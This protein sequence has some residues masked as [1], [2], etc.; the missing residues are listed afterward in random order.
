MVSTD[1]VPVTVCIPAWNEAATIAMTIE[2]VFH[3]DYP[4]IEEIIVCT[5]ACTDRTEEIVQSMDRPGLRLLSIPERGKALAWNRLVAECRTEI[6][7]FIDADI[8]IPPDC[9]GGLVNSLCK[10]TAIINSATP[11][12]LP[13]SIRRAARVLK[14]PVTI[15]R[16]GTI[17]ACCY[18]VKLQSLF[19]HLQ[20]RGLVGM[21]S[22]LIAD[23]IW[24][25]RIVGDH[26]W[27]RVPEATAWYVPPSGF[28]VFA[29]ARRN[30][31]GH[32]QIR[33]YYSHHFPVH[34]RPPPS[35]YRRLVSAW[36]DSGSLIPFAR[37]VLAYG[38]RV[39]IALIAKLQVLF[40]SR[41]SRL[42]TWDRASSTKK[43]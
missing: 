15:S 5:N 24:L 39:G 4:G 6:A 30:I 25:T 34:M 35:G 32:E 29:V 27:I 10:N 20:N 38:M 36:R 26:G 43:F 3:Q 22:G 19:R 33:R 41:S 2:S 42:D 21:P 9:V 17:T 12:P 14:P 11:N 1:I 18:A 7:V 28:D 31:R 16:S 13:G 23:H 40:E 37:K 8:L